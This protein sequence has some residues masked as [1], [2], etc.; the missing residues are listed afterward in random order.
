M[1]S[2]TPGKKRKGLPTSS[3]AFI[4]M[5]QA[6]GLCRDLVNV[7]PPSVDVHIT[8]RPAGQART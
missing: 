3:A 7:A 1:Y 2:L 5:A 6:K 4:S 8:G